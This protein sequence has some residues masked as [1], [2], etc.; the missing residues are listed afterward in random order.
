VEVAPSTSKGAAIR[1]TKD[2]KVGIIRA[3]GGSWSALIAELKRS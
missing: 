1:D 3:D 2:R